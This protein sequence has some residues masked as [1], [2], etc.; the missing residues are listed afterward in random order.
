VHSTSRPGPG[1][2]TLLIFSQSIA[3]HVKADTAN[4]MSSTI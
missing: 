4:Q 2:G 1:P 3:D